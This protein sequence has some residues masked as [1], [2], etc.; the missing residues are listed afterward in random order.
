LF[1]VLENDGRTEAFSHPEDGVYTSWDLGISD[2]T[3]IWFWRVNGNGLDFNDH[4]EDSGKPLSFFMDELERKPYAYVRHYLPHDARART[5]VSGVSVQDEMIRRAGH[6]K[7]A[8]VPH[9]SLPD[10][11]Q[12]TRKLLSS[13]QT[14]FH[15]RCDVK[16][17][18]NDIRPFEAIRNY[19]YE[20]DED[21]KV[22]AKKP[23]HDWSSHTAD[24]LRYAAVVAQMTMQLDRKE[25]EP[26]KPVIPSMDKTFNLE[27]LWEQ[28]DRE[29]RN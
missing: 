23:F 16:K 2:A 21:N 10:G 20:W 26:P 29:R 15:A 14:R 4:I 28:R 1:E 25:P 24:A 8:I 17:L 12:A 9:L 22:L 13:K 18:A 27:D 19:H 3:A 7:V 5:L 11:L 6:Q